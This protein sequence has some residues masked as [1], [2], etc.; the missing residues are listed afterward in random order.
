M[1]IPSPP[2][3][4]RLC[5]ESAW[6]TSP[7]H[8]QQGLLQTCLHPP[9]RVDQLQTT[10]GGR[11]ERWMNG[12]THMYRW[13]RTSCCAHLYDLL[14]SAESLQTNGKAYHDLERLLHALEVSPARAVFLL[15]TNVRIPIFRVPIGVERSMQHIN[16]KSKLGTNEGSSRRKRVRVQHRAYN[17]NRAPPI[18]YHGRL[19]TQDINGERSD[20]RSCCYQRLSSL[21]LA[22]YPF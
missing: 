11:I 8:T 20:R 7:V 22:S 12:T 10:V 16:F 14:V 21:P 4:L 15:I 3:P 19:H 6:P 17:I 9:A 13:M 5:V 18:H 1:W 2:N